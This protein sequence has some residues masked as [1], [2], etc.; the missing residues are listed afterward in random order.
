LITARDRSGNR[1]GLAFFPSLKISPMTWIQD[2]W[3][4]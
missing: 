1:S 2:F 3:E 4:A